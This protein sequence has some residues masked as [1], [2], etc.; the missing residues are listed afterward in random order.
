MARTCALLKPVD[1]TGVGE[2]VGKDV[3]EEV[4]LDERFVVLDGDEDEIVVV[5]DVG[6]DD[7][8]IVVLPLL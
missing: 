8:V 3:G 1:G 6:A 4:L 2:E 7:A 5:R